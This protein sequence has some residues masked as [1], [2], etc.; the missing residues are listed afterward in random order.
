MRHITRLSQ[1]FHDIIFKDTSE[2]LC[3]RAWRLQHTSRFW[4]FWTRVF[5]RVHCYRS[6]MRYWHL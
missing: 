2:S 5:G 6:Y 4:K 3:S 1:I